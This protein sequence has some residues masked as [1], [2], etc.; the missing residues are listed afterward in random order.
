MTCRKCKAPLPPD[1]LYC[2]LCGAKQAIQERKVSKRANGTGTAVR[3]PG[4]T[5]W[6][7]YVTIGYNAVTG[8]AIRRTKGGFRSKSAA[9]AYT[10]ALMGLPDGKP[11][12]LRHYYDIRLDNA[13]ISRSKQTAYRIAWNRLAPLHHKPV[14]S[15]D[16]GTVQTLV[17]NTA[18]SHYTARDVRSLLS[19]LFK[20]AVADGQARVNLAEFIKIPALDEAEANPFTPEELLML[21]STYEAGSAMCG[22]VLLM[23]YTGMMPGELLALRK[24]MIDFDARLIVGGGIKTKERKQ[25]PIVLPHIILPVF[26]ALMDL[27]S[28]A[29]VYPSNRDTFYKQYAEAITLTGCRKLPPYACRH[30]TATALALGNQVAPSVIQRVMRHT[31]IATTQRYIHPDNKA[32]LA[33]VDTM[34]K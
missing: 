30:T 9:L 27:S 10:P 28:K 33:A 17:Q 1:A 4:Q 23:V 20:L 11:R 6:T 31:R 12:E 34:F 29:T 19:H 26:S 13:D 16:I 32:A 24:D 14:G 7:L 3:R 21:W 18:P 5:T 25:K 22:Y 15:L 8:C 2:H